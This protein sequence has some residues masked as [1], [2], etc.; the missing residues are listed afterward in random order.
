MILTNELKGIIVSRGLT[1]GKVAEQL[2]IS[3]KTFSE[4]M[5]KGVFSSSEIE[6]MIVLLDIKNPCEIFFANLVT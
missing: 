6:A 4:K 3:S 1:Q 2:G 5:K